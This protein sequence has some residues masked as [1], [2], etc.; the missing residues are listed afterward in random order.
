M[1]EI[2]VYTKEEFRTILT[3]TISLVRQEI[4]N[5]G[6][7]MFVLFQLYDLRNNIVKR[8]ITKNL[9]DSARWDFINK[10]YTFAGFAAK[11]LD[12]DSE[13]NEYLSSVFYY[14]IKYESLPGNDVK[15]YPNIFLIVLVVSLFINPKAIKMFRHTEKVKVN[16]EIAQ[17]IEKHEEIKVILDKEKNCDLEIIENLIDSIDKVLAKNTLNE[18]KRTSLEQ[19]RATY[20]KLA[21]FKGS[22]KY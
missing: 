1:Q 7:F 15:R 22:T 17:I 10:R 21:K 19:M 6:Y 12:D 5:N 18:E 2:K 11:N 9:D 14:A 16:N 13:L 8:G 20:I 3:K 4:K